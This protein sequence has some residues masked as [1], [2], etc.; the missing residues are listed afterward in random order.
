MYLAE[1]I[2]VSE[3]IIGDI[4]IIINQIFIYRIVPSSVHAAFFKA[5][6]C[7]RIKVRKIPVD[8]VTFKV[9]LVKMKAAINKR[10]C[11]LVGS[12]PNFPFGTVDDIEAIGQLGLEYD[13]PVHVDACLGG[14]LLPFLEED[15]IRYDFRVPGVSSIS[16]DSHKY[17]LAPKGSSVVLYRN[18]ELLHNQYFCDADWQGGIYASATMEG[19]RAGHNIALC[20]AAMLYHA[21]EG[22]KAN[23]R[24]IVDTTRK[25]RNGLS[26]IKG[27]KLQGPSDVCIVS[28]TTND[29]V[30]LYRF[31]NFMKE[32]HW[33]LNGLQFP[34]GLVQLIFY[35]PIEILIF[36]DISEFISWSL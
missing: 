6:E 3:C 31:H 25:I 16:A 27:I 35:S 10:T 29:G 20:W 4:K 18:K 28:W 14:F 23:A 22:Y 2:V 36:V 30:E 24:K 1:K 11:M 9:D 33:Q 7:F 5:A 32:K 17:G 15:E 19:S 13:I 21:Q 12:A 8:P 26:N 34:A